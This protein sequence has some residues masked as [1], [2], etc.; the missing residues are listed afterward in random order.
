MQKR[1]L[2]MRKTP[3]QK[4]IQSQKKSNPK[5]KKILRNRKRLSQPTT[6]VANTSRKN[7]P[8]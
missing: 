6:T 4:R 5:R 2:R 8:K 1:P 3:A 7:S